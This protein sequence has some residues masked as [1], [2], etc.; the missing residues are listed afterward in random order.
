[1]AI[2][3]DIGIPLRS[4]LRR[5]GAQLLDSD[6]CLT[7]GLQCG[8][9]A[10]IAFDCLGQAVERLDHAY[11]RGRLPSQRE[12]RL[13]GRGPRPLDGAA[14]PV[15]QRHARGWIVPEVDGRALG[16]DLRRRC[17]MPLQFGVV[18]SFEIHGLEVEVAPSQPVALLAVPAL[19]LL[20]PRSR[21]EDLT[22]GLRSPSQLRMEQ[23]RSLYYQLRPWIAGFLG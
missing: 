22:R 11:G 5:S 14:E 18:E 20:A 19:G 10:G 16:K 4:D 3:G 17:K 23:E 21:A 12:Q 15:A 8:Q 1:M 2:L 7:I 6:G 9:R 13:L